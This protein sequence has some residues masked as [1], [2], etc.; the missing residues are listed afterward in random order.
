MSISIC[1]HA[2]DIL[3]AEKQFQAME[4]ELKD[5]KFSLRIRGEVHPEAYASYS[6]MVNCAINDSAYETVVLV[7]DKVLIKPGELSR[8]LSLLSAGFGYVALYSVGFFALTKS[9]IKKVG[10]FDER[11]LGGGYED[12]DFVLRMRL[13]D[14]AIF[15]SYES[16]YD[17]IATKTKQSVTAPLSLSEPHFQKKWQITDEY[18]VKKLPEESYQKYKSLNNFED[19]RWL[20]WHASVLG[21][22]S[23]VGPKKGIPSNMHPMQFQGPSRAFRFCKVPFGYDTV[24]TD[25]KVIEE[26]ENYQ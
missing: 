22:R 1:L 14:I 7:N 8:M 4:E 6:E 13:N 20:P 23:G 9:L 25:K 3:I 21:Y 2:S 15:D 12:D 24:G 18:I 26:N 5:K 11:F 17:Y 16:D 19:K 10:W